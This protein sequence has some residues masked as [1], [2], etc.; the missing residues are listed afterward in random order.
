MPGVSVS[1]N[2]AE[3]NAAAFSDGVF[4]SYCFSTFVEKIVHTGSESLGFLKKIIVYC[5]AANITKLCVQFWRCLSIKLL[6]VFTARGKRG[7][8]LVSLK[9]LLHWPSSGEHFDGM[10]RKN[11]YPTDFA[12]LWSAKTG[13]PWLNCPH[14]REKNKNIDHGDPVVRLSPTS[15]IASL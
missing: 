10:D 4:N 14:R 13:S 3:K 7:Y 1:V 9:S 12:G 11:D 5:L 8:M 2:S 15:N 6:F